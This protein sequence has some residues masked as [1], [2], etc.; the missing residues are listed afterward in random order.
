MVNAIIQ[1][2]A[3][4]KD[5][6][7]GDA[8]ETIYFGGG[9]PSLLTIHELHRIFDALHQHHTLLPNAEITLE[10][11]PDDLS[12][13][14]LAALSQTPINR[15]SIGIQSFSDE[16]LRFMNRAH[17]AQEATKCIQLAQEVGFQNLTIDL[18]YGTPTLSHTTWLENLEKTFRYNIP[19][20]SC[21]CLTVEPKTALAY[22]VKKGIVSNVNEEHAAK[23]FELLLTAT[24]ANGY[25]QYE[26]SNFAQNQQYSRH[27]TSY[28]LGK[29]YLGLGPGAHS[30]DGQNRQWNI[31]HNQRYIK[32][33]QQNQCPFEKEI[34]SEQDRYNEYLMTALRTKWGCDLEKLATWGTDF[35]AHFLKNTQ[36]FLEHGMMKRQDTIFTLT[37]KGRFLADGI[38]SDL[39]WV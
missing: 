39:F 19:H 22:R 1:E 5:F 16:D 13:T 24:K 18:I 25:E 27:N 28:W 6:L 33:I 11:N 34:L 32:A 17:N 29:K 12:K 9:T 38:M 36:R 2:I 37:E 4:Q 30:F 20:L 8:I 10:A 35:K 26:I 15:L 7:K 23:Q 31:A 3:L 14:K 21:Y